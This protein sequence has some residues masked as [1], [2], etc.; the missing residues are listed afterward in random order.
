MIYFIGFLLLCGIL[1]IVH[2]WVEA[3]KVTIEKKEIQLEHYP[4]SFNGLKVFFISDI[5]TRTIDDRLLD[6][7]DE[8]IDLVVIGGDLMEKGVPFDRVSRNLDKLSEIAPIYFV[9]GNNDYE[10][11]FRR[12]DV[13]LKDKGVTI[14]DNTCARFETDEDVLHL[15]GVDDPTLDRDELRLAL[16]DIDERGYRILISHN[17]NIME[18]LQREDR[19][20]A[21]LSGHTHGG[22]IR[23]FKWGIAARGGISRHAGTLLFISNGFGYTQ[24]PFRL[25]APA[26]T[27]VL[28]FS[29]STSSKT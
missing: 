8:P 21:V 6:Q 13:L 7:I 14:L 26:Q 20:G 22:Q 12:L 4:V 2:M 23:F 17:P 28:T 16:Q 5:H 11:D 10:V 18:K 27:H 15:I 19:I 29:R 24:L 9:W 3:H 1:L 25:C